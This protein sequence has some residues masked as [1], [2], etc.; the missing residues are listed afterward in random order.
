MKIWN[1]CVITFD[2]Y[3][4]TV[5]KLSIYYWSTN[6]YSFREKKTFLD[7][8]LINMS[9]IQISNIMVQKL[10]VGQSIYKLFVNIRIK[11]IKIKII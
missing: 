11:H 1:I 5:W 2:P 3:Y 8:N 6:S 10:E 4:V 9:T 7:I